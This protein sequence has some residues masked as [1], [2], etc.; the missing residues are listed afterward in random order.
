MTRFLTLERFICQPSVREG[1][2]LVGF[3]L[4]NKVVARYGAAAAAFRSLGI[5]LKFEAIYRR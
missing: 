3:F 4:A 5:V 2:F 1:E